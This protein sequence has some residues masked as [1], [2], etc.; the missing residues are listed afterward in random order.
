MELQLRGVRIQQEG[1]GTWER[2]SGIQKAGKE[3]VAEEL[4]NQAAREAER[5]LDCG[6]E[7]GGEPSKAPSN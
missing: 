5:I 2:I 7:L 6:S 3:C 1:A 4:G